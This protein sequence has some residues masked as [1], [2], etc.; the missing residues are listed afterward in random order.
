MPLPFPAHQGLIL[1]VA[2]KWSHHFDV[3]ALC[4]GAAMPD[5]ADSVVGFLS[6]GYFSHGY[7]HSLTGIVL[8]DLPSGILLVY[9]TLALAARFGKTLPSKVAGIR[10][11]G[12]SMFVGVA[13]H[14]GFDLISH[15]TNWLFYPWFESGYYFPAW[16]YITWFEVTLPFFGEPY[17]VGPHVVAWIILTLAG[18][19]LFVRFFTPE[20]AAEK[21]HAGP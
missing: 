4:I 9:I 14:V 21:K 13:S 11:L 19:Y 20:A 16:W 8:L 15:R 3:L 5:I 2:R 17:P 10:Q 6:Q 18:T 7:G 1:P 12:F